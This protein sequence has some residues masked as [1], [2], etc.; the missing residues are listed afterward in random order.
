MAPKRHEAARG[1]PDSEGYTLG[2]GGIW[3][4]GSPIHMDGDRTRFLPQ[5]GPPRGHPKPGVPGL[6]LPG[7]LGRFSK[8]FLEGQGNAPK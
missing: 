5:K 8:P 6:E 3:L 1:L 4:S 2:G 7:T